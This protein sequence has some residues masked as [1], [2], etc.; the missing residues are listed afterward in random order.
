MDCWGGALQQAIRR[1][2]EL[3]Q[4][5]T[6]GSAGQEHA[7]LAASGLGQRP[8]RGNPES[9]GEISLGPPGPLRLPPDD[10]RAMPSQSSRWLT[11]TRTEQSSSDARRAARRKSPT[12]IFN[13]AARRTSR[14]AWRRTMPSSGR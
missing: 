5:P 2:A 14:L 11:G 4:S 12:H 6:G 3:G 9:E 1:A 8:G 13:P 7:I 10:R